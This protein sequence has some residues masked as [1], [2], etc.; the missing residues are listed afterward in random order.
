MLDK[1]RLRKKRKVGNPGEA[2]IEQCYKVKS[3]E[4][5]RRLRYCERDRRC[6]FE[7]ELRDKLGDLTIGAVHNRDES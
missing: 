6:R 5:R 1:T 2:V 3:E 4:E 7:I